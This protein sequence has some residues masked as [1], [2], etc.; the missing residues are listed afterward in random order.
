MRARRS[1][2]VVQVSSMMGLMSLAG[3]S[4]YCAAKGALEQ[5]SEALAA[6][7]GPLGI[8]VLI[9]INECLVPAC[10]AWHLETITTASTGFR[11]APGT[12]L[13]GCSR[14]ARNLQGE[15]DGYS[16]SRITR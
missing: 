14:S 2:T 8:G 12:D 3:A 9:V 1:G 15:R 6:E 11:P 13:P 4:A 16:A 7:A 10:T 5:A